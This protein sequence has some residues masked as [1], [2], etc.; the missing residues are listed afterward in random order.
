MT[1]GQ[2]SLLGD[3]SDEP[4]DLAVSYSADMPRIKVRVVLPDEA[5]LSQHA[6]QLND[7]DKTCKGTSLWKQ[8]ELQA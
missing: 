4:I 6:Q 2:D 3:G 7:I 5:E 1:R 8:L